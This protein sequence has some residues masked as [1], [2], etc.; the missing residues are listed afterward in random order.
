VRAVANWAWPHTPTSAAARLIL[1]DGPFHGEEVGFL[2]PDLP[3]P[4]QIAWGGWFP[5]GFAT[6]LYEWRGQ[7]T[8]MDQGRTSALI[9]RPVLVQDEYMRV[10]KGRRL[11]PE[12]IPPAM[13]EAAE[14]WADGADLLMNAWDVPAEM[15]W[16]GL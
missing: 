12:E 4:V 9:Y 2:P 11:R 15:L 8:D 14:V 13:A 3:A 5:W 1:R 10:R 16:P 6:Y 7:E